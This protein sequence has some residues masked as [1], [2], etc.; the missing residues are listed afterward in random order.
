LNFLFDLEN[1]VG[2]GATSDTIIEAKQPTSSNLQLSLTARNFHRVF[3][4]LTGVLP[5]RLQRGLS[6][7]FRRS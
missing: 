5:L 3:T 1:R 2:H 4:H 7:S 6:G